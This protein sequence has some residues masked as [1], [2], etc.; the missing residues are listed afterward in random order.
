MHAVE[1]SLRDRPWY[2]DIVNYLAIDVELEELKGYTRKNN[3]ENLGDNIGM[4][5]TSTNIALTGYIDVVLPQLK[6]QTFYS[7]A[8]DPT[9]LDILR[10]LKRYPKFFKPDYGGQLCFAMLMHS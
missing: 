8:M 4:N 3:L 1:R 6:F 10:P 9:M 2:T 7:N 5:H